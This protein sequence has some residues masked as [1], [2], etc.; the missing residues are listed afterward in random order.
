MLRRFTA[1]SGMMKTKLFL[2]AILMIILPAMAVIGDEPTPPG[3]PDA[4]LT[5]TGR[6]THTDNK[7]KPHKLVVCD[8]GGILFLKCVFDCMNEAC[9]ALHVQ[10]E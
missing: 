6:H 5:T 8:V 1:V 3:Q 9:S 7:I 10:V 2:V 4:W